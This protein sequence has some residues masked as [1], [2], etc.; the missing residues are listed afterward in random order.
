MF[1]VAHEI[2]IAPRAGAV[3]DADGRIGLDLTVERFGRA[4]LDLAERHTDVRVYFPRDVG[5]GGVGEGLPAL[6]FDGI[7]GSNHTI[8]SQ[9]C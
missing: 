9:Y 2:G 1:D 4:K 3:I 5:P 7:F 6:R 8:L